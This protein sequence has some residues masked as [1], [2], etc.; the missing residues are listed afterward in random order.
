MKIWN[1]KLVS[2]LDTI[3]P[4]YA[5]PYNEPLTV[6][7]ITYRL[8]NDVKEIEGDH[9]RYSFVHYT[10]KLHVIDLD[11]AERYLEEID[12]LLYQNRFFREGFNEIE[13]G[14]VHEFILNYSVHT[15]EILSER[16]E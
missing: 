1:K 2:L 13:V 9:L 10:I 7:C 6:P 15:K 16:T 14:N 12:T 5:E 4:T 3:L 11:D 8:S